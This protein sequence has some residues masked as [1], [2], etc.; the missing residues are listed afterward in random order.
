MLDLKV[1]EQTIK[2]SGITYEEAAQLMR[3]TRNTLHHWR[4]GREPRV[5]IQAEFAMHQ[6][7]KLITGIKQGLLPLPKGLT[8]EDRIKAIFDIAKII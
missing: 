1:I 5:Q 6:I 7:K 8:P 3:V 2:A 4:Q